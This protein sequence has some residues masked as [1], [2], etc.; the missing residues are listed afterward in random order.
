MPKHSYLERQQ[1]TCFRLCAALADMRAGG[2]AERLLEELA[3]VSLRSYQ[4]FVLEAVERGVQH[5]D[6][7]ADA[8]D[9]DTQTVSRA[10]SELYTLRLVERAR[11][12]PT[13]RKTRAHFRYYALTKRVSAP[14]KA[15]L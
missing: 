1:N 11:V 2:D 10:L 5:T 4:L 6:E 7:I 3:R 9:M 12:E 8:L 13:H 15:V 14:E